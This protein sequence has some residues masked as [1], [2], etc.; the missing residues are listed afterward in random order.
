MNTDKIKNE[1]TEPDG[2]GSEL[3]P[4]LAFIDEVAPEHQRTSCTDDS[5]NGN[6]FFNEFGSPRCVRCALLHRAREG[7]WPCGVDAEIRSIRFSGHPRI[8]EG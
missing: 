5:S 1:A 8:T 4:L 6:Q 2:A 7:E 3:T